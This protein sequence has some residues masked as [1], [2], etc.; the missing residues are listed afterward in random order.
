MATLA[1]IQAELRRRDAEAKAAEEKRTAGGQSGG[2]NALFPFW[3]TKVGETATMRWLS[4]G[5]D[6]NIFPWV[7]RQTI[8]LTFDGTVGGERDTTER[9]KVKVPCPTMFQK[10][11]PGYNIA[12][13]ITAAI[14][15]L[16][17]YPKDSKEYKQ[18]QTYYRKQSWLMQGLVVASP[19]TEENAPKNPIRRAA[20]TKQVF[21][22]V[23]KAY[24]GTGFEHAPHDFDN[25][26]DFIFEPKH[27]GEFKNWEGSDFARR[28]RSLSAEERAAIAEFG[29][30]TL[31]DYVGKAPT[32]QDADA[33]Y[34]MYLDSVAGLPYD[35]AKFGDFYRPYGVKGP[36]NGGNSE[37]SAADQTGGASD[38]TPAAANPAPVSTATPAASSE[39]TDDLIAR[40]RRNSANAG[41]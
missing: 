14:R 6:S 38:R 12:C 34:Q 26:T 25:G 29:L 15:P 33:Q 23:F 3:D 31:K 17:K 28:E 24:N 36:N 30:F 37:N 2:D 11:I 40:I 27:Q 10:I 20:L 39:T 18:A 4:D 8:E 16:W 35:F 21:T 41:A 13:Q 1:E 32:Q 7:E 19:F 5:D 22:K 9:V